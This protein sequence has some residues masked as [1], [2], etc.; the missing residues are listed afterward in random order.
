[1]TVAEVISS[2]PEVQGGAAVFAGT[3][4]PVKNL[5]DYLEAGDSLEQFLDDFPSVTREQAVAAL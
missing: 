4:V 1:M 2:D 5:I 3:R